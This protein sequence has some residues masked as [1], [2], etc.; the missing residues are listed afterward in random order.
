MYY[1]QRDKLLI[2]LEKAGEEIAKLKVNNSNLFNSLQKLE[3]RKTEMAEQV[4]WLKTIKYA[5]SGMEIEIYCQ[6]C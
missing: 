2:D 5:T 4:S 1:F 3:L 6:L